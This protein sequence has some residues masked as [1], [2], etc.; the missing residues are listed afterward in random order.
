[1]NEACEFLIFPFL[2]EFT[3]SLFVSSLEPVKAVSVKW[4]EDDGITI[5]AYVRQLAFARANCSSSLRAIAN[6]TDR[7]KRAHGTSPQCASRHEHAVHRST[8][9]GSFLYLPSSPFSPMTLPS[10]LFLSFLLHYN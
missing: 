10:Y 5:I 9:V 3:N 8:W 4:E 2:E 6:T 1:M 7:N